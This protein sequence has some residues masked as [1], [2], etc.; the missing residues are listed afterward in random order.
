MA[1]NYAATVKTAR[2]TA[3]RDAVADGTLEIQDVGGVALAIFGLVLSGG[4]VTGDAWTLEFDAATV[5][6]V[7]GSN[8]AAT[9]A[10]I[11]TAGGAAVITGLTV[12]VAAATPDVVLDSANITTGQNVTLSSAVI[13]HAA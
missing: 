12:G 11:K 1:V 7:A 2:M 6:A 10:V 3:T 8:T 4:T 5:A 9:Q 13:Q